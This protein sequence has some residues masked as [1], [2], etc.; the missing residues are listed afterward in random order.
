[1]NDIENRITRLERAVAALTQAAINIEAYCSIIADTLP[2][3]LP[4]DADTKAQIQHR[5]VQERLEMRKA[6]RE[7]VIEDGG[8]LPE[9]S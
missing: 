5:L 1:M 2:N 3:L 6:L 8:V 7:Q 9:G 4:G